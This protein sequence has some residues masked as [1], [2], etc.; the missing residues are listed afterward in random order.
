MSL[1]I[2][3][4]ANLDI[5]QCFLYD[6]APYMK[7]GAVSCKGTFTNYTVNAVGLTT[8]YMIK[9]EQ[10]MQVQLIANQWENYIEHAEPFDDNN[11]TEY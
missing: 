9:F 2:F 3:P 6:S 7:I 4:F 11:T 1:N 8:G 10:D 5:G